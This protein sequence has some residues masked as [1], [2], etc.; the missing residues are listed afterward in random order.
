M[1]RVLVRRKRFKIW[2]II[3]T[4]LLLQLVLDS[5]VSQNEISILHSV[6]T[7]MIFSNV[8]LVKTR[9]NF[10]RELSFVPGQIFLHFAVWYN[11]ILGIIFRKKVVDCNLRPNFFPSTPSLPGCFS[12]WN[13][14]WRGKEEE[15]S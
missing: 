6:S 13:Y 1:I 3:E 14:S 11:E 10:P 7:Q 5:R 12:L 8:E 15:E 9:E 4:P 2:L